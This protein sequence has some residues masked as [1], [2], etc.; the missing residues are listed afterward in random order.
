[1]LLTFQELIVSDYDI[2]RNIMSET[3]VL[4]DINANLTDQRE[5]YTWLAH[6]TTVTGSSGWMA[7]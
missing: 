2:L 6:M 3:D 1:V 4:C 5:N 7:N